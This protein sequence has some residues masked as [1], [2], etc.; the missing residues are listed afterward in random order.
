VRIISGRLKGQR[1]I[2]PRVVNF[3]PIQSVTRK[4][5]FDS[6]QFLLKPEHFFLDL[7]GGS[8]SVGFE[9]FSRGIENVLVVES[10]HKNFEAIQKTAKKFKTGPGFIILNMDFRDALS[11]SLN[12]GWVF[13]YIFCAPPYKKKEYYDIVLNFLRNNPNF[14][15]SDGLLI[16]E[17]NKKFEPDISGFDKIRDKVYGI[18]RVISLKKGKD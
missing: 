8:G 11:Y 15:A 12:K 6:L 10:D 18:A 9:A 17:S 4:A 13:N 16:L 1:L 2:L 5:I 3:R 14:L 7:F